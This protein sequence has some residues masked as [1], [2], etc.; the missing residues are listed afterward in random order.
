MKILVTICARG[1][2]KGVPGKNIKPLN[3]KPL[4]HYTLET[5]F[6][7][8]EKYQADLQISTDRQEILDCAALMGYH[9]AYIRPDELATDK[10]G[11]MDAIR[12]AWEFAESNFGKSYDYVIDLDVTSPLRNLQDMESAYKLLLN[13]PHA[14]NIFSVNKAARN[15]YFNMVEDGKDGFVKVIKNIGDLKSRQDAP[16]V[17]DMNASFYIFTREFMAGNFFISTTDRSLAYVMPHI[18]FDIDEPIDFK[19]MELLMKDGSLGFS[20]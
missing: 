5:A 14:L 15:P 11:K 17:Y 6:S 19:I 1:G 8:C 9:T 2:S 13:S 20:L 4:L 10:A 12:E 18:C 3:G 7:F 16:K